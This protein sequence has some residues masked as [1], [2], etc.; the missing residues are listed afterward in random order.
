[1]IEEQNE[2]K[3]SN[4]AVARKLVSSP[5]DEADD[6]EGSYS[7][8]ADSHTDKESDDN[9]RSASPPKRPRRNSR[10]MTPAH[11]RSK[12]ARKKKSQAQREKKERAAAKRV[13]GEQGRTSS[14]KKTRTSGGSP[15]GQVA[16]ASRRTKLAT[17]SATSTR[18]KAPSATPSALAKPTN[19]VAQSF[20]PPRPSTRTSVSN[21]QHK[22][23]TK[24]AELTTKQPATVTKRDTG[25][26][27]QADK[28]GKPKVNI[29]IQTFD[30]SIVGTDPKLVEAIKV[31]LNKH[32]EQKCNKANPHMMMCAAMHIQGLS[33]DLGMEEEISL[34]KRAGLWD[35]KWDR[36]GLHPFGDNRQDKM[37]RSKLLSE[38]EE[39][40]KDTG[41]EIQQFEL[42]SLAFKVNG[43][44]GMLYPFEIDKICR[45]LPSLDREM[46]V[47]QA[48]MWAKIC[49]GTDQEAKRKAENAGKIALGEEDLMSDEASCGPNSDSKVLTQAH[50][51]FLEKYHAELRDLD[52]DERDDRGERALW[53]CALRALGK[54]S[55]M[56]DKD[57]EFILEA[58]P[59]LS[60]DY[61]KQYCADKY[62]VES[63]KQAPVDVTKEEKQTTKRAKITTK[64]TALARPLAE[65][66]EDLDDL[67]VEATIEG[68]EEGEEDEDD[69]EE[70]EAE[71]EAEE[72]I[73]AIVKE[74]DKTNMK[75]NFFWLRCKYGDGHEED[76]KLGAVKYE[77]PE[78]VEKYLQKNRRQKRAWVWP[79][80]EKA[81]PKQ[82][83][84]IVLILDYIGEAGKEEEGKFDVVWD[85]GL[86]EVCTYE[87]TKKNSTSAKLFRDFIKELRS[88]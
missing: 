44:R 36:I 76:V 33:G 3:K 20:P 22:G 74:V 80:P 40:E 6:S 82:G 39:T 27:K 75:G 83:D 65:G 77:F 45:A 42:Y 30:K 16:A 59:N 86:R 1:L 68:G 52:D 14:G 81:D 41:R 79:V 63:A 84:R 46:V 15:T 8:V 73:I 69:D 12:G 4:K 53:D 23:V 17:A 11:K 54:G 7:L 21:T 55:S 5:S 58:A 47:K 66:E 38:I 62:G 61:F 51:D 43:N 67:D 2:R 60:G 28:M 64:K 78:V 10:E 18:K 88:G 49:V 37:F 57:I 71:M 72:T 26:T 24:E 70:E 32:G 35:P 85:I 9:S 56:T 13:S 87:E 34:A 48:E 29:P 50:K 31:H 25:A 19:F